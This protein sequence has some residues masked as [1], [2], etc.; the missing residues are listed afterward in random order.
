LS[1]GA[2]SSAKKAIQAD[3]STTFTGGQAHHLECIKPVLMIEFESEKTIQ[4]TQNVPWEKGNLPLI[5]PLPAPSHV[6]QLPG[7]R[8]HHKLF[9]I[10][11]RLRSLH[12]S[13]KS[14]IGVA[15]YSIK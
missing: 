8:E 13:H 9:E 3:E 15:S 6:F 5:H 12:S 14:Q 11:A 10:A 4:L 7:P 1:Q 2:D